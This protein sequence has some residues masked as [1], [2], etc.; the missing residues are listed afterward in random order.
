M[1][2]L[3]EPPMERKVGRPRKDRDDVTVK[4]D[5]G[6]VVKAKLVAVARKMSLAEYLSD[7]IRGPVDRDF[8]KEMRKVEEGGSK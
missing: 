7:L 2:K 8:A 6:I 3:L 4:V 1:V 5:R